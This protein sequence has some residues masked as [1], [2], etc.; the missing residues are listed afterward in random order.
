MSGVETIVCDD[1]ALR[2]SGLTARA[3]GPM[4]AHNVAA[5]RRIAQLH[6]ER[7]FGLVYSNTQTVL[8]GAFM[9]RTLRIPH[10]WH[11]HEIFREP[12][13]LARPLAQ[14][15]AHSGN[16]VVAC[17]RSVKEALI[18]GAPRVGRR[19]DIVLNGVDLPSRPLA[20]EPAD[21]V[22]R[23]GCVA[24]IHPRKGQELLVRALALLVHEKPHVGKTLEVHY[25]G[26][27]F[28]GQEHLARDLER[29]ARELGVSEQ[30]QMHGFVSDPACVYPN[31]DVLVLPS[32][33]P[34]PFGLVCV[35]AMGY[36]RVVVA[37]R[38]AGP[39]EIV[40]DGRTGILFEPRDARSLA[41][42]IERVV[43]DRKRAHQIAAA[44]RVRAVERFGIAR[45]RT[46]IRRVLLRAAGVTAP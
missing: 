33:E 8:V 19:V 6:R 44:G 23:L 40:D 10:V 30:I 9:A 7:R 16:A 35:E 28:P 11:V 4:L 38:E 42:A 46:E 41:D 15:V 2:R 13:L 3:V 21:D 32:V 36:G 1:Y 20:Y 26:S 25:F 5:G 18:D 43:A 17:S 34:E 12:A 31:I 14:A 29:L 37:P 22:V 27:P 39:T 24:R 45:Y